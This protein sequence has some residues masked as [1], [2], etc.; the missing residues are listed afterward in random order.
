MEFV[1][2][3]NEILRPFSETFCTKLAMLIQD[4]LSILL[5]FKTSWLEI[6]DKMKKE[7]MELYLQTKK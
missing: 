1:D 4:Y 2:G 5:F 3:K 7:L 6:E